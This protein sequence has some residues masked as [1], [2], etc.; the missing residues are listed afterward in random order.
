MEQEVEQ[1]KTLVNDLFMKVEVCYSCL[2][3]RISIIG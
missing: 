3:I 2:L 1:L